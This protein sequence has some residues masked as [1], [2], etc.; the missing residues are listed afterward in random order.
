MAA[1]SIGMRMWSSFCTRGKMHDGTPV[2][3]FVAVPG[4]PHLFA[5]E[6]VGFAA[7]LVT[8]DD[9]KRGVSWRTSIFRSKM[10]AE[11][12]QLVARAVLALVLEKREEI[13]ADEVTPVRVFPLDAAHFTTLFVLSPEVEDSNVAGGLLRRSLWYVFPGFASE[14]SGTESVKLADARC[15][16][17]A[18]IPMAKW[19]RKPHPVLDL[20]HLKKPGEKPT[21]LVYPPDR[22]EYMLGEKALSKLSKVEVQARNYKGEVRRF[23]KGDTP[24]LSELRAFFGF[25]G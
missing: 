11:Q 4:T 18:H 16:G 6:K 22:L 7:W 25:S 24:D 12:R 21:F 1:A 2:D 14:M 5:F 9:R 3:P 17:H 19:D 10:P 8:S 23:V 15:A 20:A 13:L